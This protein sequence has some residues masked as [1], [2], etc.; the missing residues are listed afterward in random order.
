MSSSIS[1]PERAT[2][3]R[4]IAFFTEKL[5]YRY[6][7]DW[8][9]RQGNH[10]IEEGLLTAHLA[11]RGYSPTHISTA[12]HRLRSEAL[13]HGRTL[14]AANQAVYR[15]M[16]YGVP[17]KVAAGEVN[18]TV[19]LVNWHKPENNDFAI[20]EEVTLNGGEERRP[21]I[22]LYLNG[23][24]VG[25]LELK[26]SRVSLGEGIRQCLSNQQPEFNEWFFSTMQLVMAGN[27]SEGLRYGTIETPEKFFLSWKEDE[28]DNAGYKLDKY[29]A[30][31]CR[32]ARLL[33][34]VHDFVLFDGG[35]KK[36][37]RVHQYFGMKAAQAHVQQR[38]GGII[39][40]TQGAGKSILMVCAPTEF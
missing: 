2:Q 24:A 17:V 13:L 1:K 16:R 22:V 5:H 18:E 25:M 14:Y 29:L 40:H 20:A 9:H 32:P 8:S 19:H 12:L 31:L 35:V 37:P 3:D 27:D 7:G 33:E 34:L 26:N 28:A 38:R 4:V 23:I 15:L 10:C 6:L 21:D 39:W 36:L 11:G 30:K